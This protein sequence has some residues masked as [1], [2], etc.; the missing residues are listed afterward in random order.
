[1]T[2]DKEKLFARIF[3]RKEQEITFC[4]RKSVKL[5]IFSQDIFQQ[6]KDAVSGQQIWRGSVKTE[7]IIEIAA[8]F[9]REK[10]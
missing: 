1:M 5:E 4:F 7:E 9:G 3:F 6:E 10:I 8:F 2:W